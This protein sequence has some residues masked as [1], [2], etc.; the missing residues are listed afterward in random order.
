MTS[1]STAS[2]IH[3]PAATDLAGAA[4]ALLDPEDFFTTTELYDWVRADLC[5]VTSGKCTSLPGQLTTNDYAEATGANQPTF[6]A[7]GFGGRAS[8]L[9]D[10]TTVG[11][12]LS[13]ETCLELASGVR[14]GMLIVGQ[15]TLTVQDGDTRFVNWDDGSAV[16]TGIGIEALGTNRYKVT[17]ELADGTA[18]PTGA[19]ESMDANPHIFDFRNDATASI[20]NV[21][22]APV[23]DTENGLSANAIDAIYIGGGAGGNAGLGG[24]DWRIAMVLFFKTDPGETKLAAFRDEAVSFYGDVI[25]LP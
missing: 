3:V 20:L 25:T 6:E 23:T 22:E 14:F 7:A 15:S 16:R 1:C 8:L 21:D 4:E 18:K 24:G 11:Q 9:F 10:N 19:A 5:S 13:D 2:R 12:R 17:A